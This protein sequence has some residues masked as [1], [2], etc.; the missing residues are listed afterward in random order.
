M[1]GQGGGV[2]P[3]MGMGANPLMGMGAN[4]FMGMGANPF[5]GMGANPYAGNATAANSLGN[6]DFSN[7][8][9][10]P[11]V[12]VSAPAV[13]PPEVRYASELRQLEAMGF[14]NQE[15]N[16]KVL[17]DVKGCV[18]AAIERLLGQ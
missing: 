13:E 12:P 14:T 17:A 4:P 2:N 7:L 15:R 8:L 5:M 11:T 6:L 16:L 1:Q 10:G 18:N 3:F 9:S